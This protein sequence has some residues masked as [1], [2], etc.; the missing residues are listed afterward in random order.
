M[1]TAYSFRGIPQ[2]LSRSALE[3]HPVE[4]EAE[5]SSTRGRFLP[6]TD[7]TVENC[8]SRNTVSEFCGLWAVE[9]LEIR[10]YNDERSITTNET[11]PSVPTPG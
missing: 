7:R 11:E 9:Q 10:E 3:L 8:E 5:V 6:N 2:I 1:S 4:R